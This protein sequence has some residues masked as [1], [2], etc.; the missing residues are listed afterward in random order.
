MQ[1]MVVGRQ[2]SCD[3]VLDSAATPQ[4][5]S[6]R[7]ALLSTEAGMCKLVDL[8]ALNGALVN[9]TPLCGEH[10]LAHGDIVTFGV[11]AAVPE[12]DYI[13]EERPDNAS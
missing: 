13:F 3:V 7:H 2:Q 1:S 9:G 4:M 11:E 6:R 12:L 5:I 10:V 8:G